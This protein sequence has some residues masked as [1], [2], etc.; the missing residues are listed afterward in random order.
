MMSFNLI[1]KAACHSSP[2]LVVTLNFAGRPKQYE[3][4]P[5]IWNSPSPFN[6]TVEKTLFAGRPLWGGPK[7]E[8]G[9]GEQMQQLAGQGSQPGWRGKWGSLL[10]NQHLSHEDVRRF[11]VLWQLLLEVDVAPLLSL[12]RLLRLSGDLFQCTRC[13]GTTQPHLS[14]RFVSGRGGWWCAHLP[15]LRQPGHLVE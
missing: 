7:E 3:E 11:S 6:V 14:V 8:T 5:T 1:S 10:L 12:L 2:N 15:K 4:K 9:R 13:V